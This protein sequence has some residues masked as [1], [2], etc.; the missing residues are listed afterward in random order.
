V[1]LKCVC[2]YVCVPV[3]SVLLGRSYHTDEMSIVDSLE[4]EGEGGLE[5]R[6][7]ILEL[8]ALMLSLFITT[9]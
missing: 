4:R 7:D 1:S 6:R 5:G 3:I 2:V 9:I 8:L